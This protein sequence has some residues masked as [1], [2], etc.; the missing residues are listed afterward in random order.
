MF[1]PLL[2]FAI[3]ALLTLSAFAQ[4]R[5]GDA[6]WTDADEKPM[7]A[8]A[9]RAAD[10]NQRRNVVPKAYRTVS[11]NRATLEK[12]LAS[13][14]NESAG[15]IESANVEITIPLPAGG[16][17]R[18]L[19][20]ESPIMDRKLAAKFPQIKTYT[21]QGIDDP[22][23]TMRMDLTPRGLH[24]AILSPRG[25]VYVDPYW[26]DSDA[27]YVAYNKSDLG[28]DR[29]FSC[30][31]EP[32]P[33]AGSVHSTS[34]ATTARPTGANLKRYR[35]AVACTGE[36]ASAVNQP[37]A[38]TVA[39][40]LSAIVTSVNRI[41]GI[42]ERDLAIR[43][44]VVGNNDKLVYLNPDTD[45]YLNSDGAAMLSQ[46]Q[47][48]IDSEIG[49]ANY[50]FG[51][52]F[53][54]F[55]GG[56]ANIAVICGASKARGVSGLPNPT[57]DPFDVDFVAHE[58]G[59]QFGANHTFNS[60]VDN[61]GSGA[62]N[63]A[64]AYEVGSGS[65]IMAYAG[66]CAT[67]NLAD[68]SDN[69]FHSASYT[70][71]DNFIS[72]ANG[73]SCA[74]TVATG[75]SPPTIAPLAAGF[76]IPAR[77]P[78]ALTAS[79]TDTNGD[80]ISY[81]WE[82][83]DLGIAQTGTN[84]IS[85]ATNPLFRSYPPTLNPTRVFPALPYILNNANVPPATNSE[86]FATGEVLPTV[87]R[88]MNFRVTAR[89]NRAGGGGSDWAAT[90]VTTVNTGAGFAITAPN[91]QATFA[92]G[93]QQTISWNVAGTTANGINC[94]N[95]KITLSTDGGNT[96]PTVLA[97]SVP[98]NGGAL[99]TLPQIATTQA[100]IK[101]EAVG[102]IFFDISNEDFAITSANAAP[103][104]GITNS[105]TVVRGKLTPT[106]ANVGTATDAN[107]DSLTVSVS[108]A[109]YG[110]T[111]SPSLNGSNISLS[112]LV[113]CAVV[114]TNTSR[115][116]P[117]RITVTDAQGAKTSSSVD[118]IVTPNASPTPATYANISVARGSSG[119]STPSPAASDPNGNLAATPYSI[120]PTA[121]AGGGP[122]S[123]NPTTGVI[124]A[125]PTNSSTIG[126]TTVR[127]TALDRCGAAAVS[128]CEVNVFAP[129]AVPQAGSASAPTQEGCTPANNAIDPGETV[130]IDLPITNIGSNATDNLVATLQ[131]TGGVTRVTTSQS[132]GAIAPNG[133]VSRPFQFVASGMCGGTITATLQLQDGSTNLGT[134]T[135]TLQLG[136]YTAAATLFQNFD[137]VTPPALPAGWTS[138]VGS[139]T[140]SPW[141]TSTTTPDSAPNSVSA[142]S[143]AS[144][145]DNR[146]V[147]PVVAVPANAP[148]L[149]FRHRWKLE[150]LFDGGI[151]E[152]SIN[153]GAYADIIAAGG[154]FVTGGYNG[155]ID[156]QTGS[157][158][159]GKNAWTGS[160]NA[161][162]TTTLVNLPAAAAGQNVRFRWRL[163]SDSDVTEAGAV[164]RID[165]INVISNSY[166]CSTSCNAPVFTSPPPPSPVIVGSPYSHTF[167]ATGSPAPTFT[168]TG[169]TLPPGLNL[170]ASGVL[171][172]TPTFAG[173][174]SF[175]NIT[176]TATNG[177]APAAQQTFSLA[178]V[179]RAANYLGGYGLTGG[180]AG[181]TFDYDGDG[182]GNG[183]EYA[184]R[185]DPT[186][187]S[188]AG[189]PVVTL[190]DF[191]GTKYLSVT[192]T[193][194]SVATDLTYIVQGSSDLI[195]W[196]DLASS[197]GGAA[198]GGPGLVTDTG[199]APVFTV[200]VRDTVPHSQAGGVKR[201]L[202]LKVTSP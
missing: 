99:V 35:L 155:T 8:A 6:L 53:S 103:N 62:R 16:F 194:S 134:I 197:V 147:S 118:L 51:H 69:Y 27:T 36:Y 179:T 180:N 24:A 138:E 192:F 76:T 87:A 176:V 98:N 133:S 21:G 28:A 183:L 5:S 201:F 181:F 154:S 80:T 186:V 47:S 128:F 9:S 102:N 198:M 40:T 63:A 70:E 64:T 172:G 89:D 189:L 107:G 130:M 195:Q 15:P 157:P 122:I 86:G 177:N 48:T 42:Y 13:A 50:D 19:V 145:S 123:V 92:G 117:L 4:S 110:A 61:C 113:D 161:S 171:S 148:Q 156:S 169:G 188:R 82:E 33:N 44:I 159:A 178:A 101:V 97:N 65:T 95:V 168:L 58:M 38:P 54:T 119:T 143:V 46:N 202:R 32:A 56:L 77:T 31:A 167:T 164:W 106:V 200:E 174:G 158:I 57:G 90:T 136:A 20:Q 34:T 140:S 17:G 83:F 30:L 74:T 3:G 126:V 141:T 94:A 96:F 91:I 193:R 29:S 18:F 199:P 162:Y 60:T 129:G 55:E 166:V 182:G 49:S 1:R 11:L 151:L 191:A 81:A 196:T 146:L 173:N 43:F 120:T 111:I 12:L 104:I 150:F 139:G 127:V 124:T 135:Y 163:A 144:V 10:V 170:S 39:N 78:F 22:T 160:F 190:K 112:A 14:P 116:Y 131:S 93:S 175:P 26:R 132:Y 149:S 100:R 152:I 114:T 41:N 2:S 109:P 7:L 59:H 165:S 108:N 125:S 185:S 72:G 73:S 105:I 75:N 68:H 84:P 88:T 142:T 66:I 37:N 79:G 137:G 23:A 52:L 85:N 67:T 153:N 121:L 25:Q 187:A 71:I 184:L 45:P 115:T